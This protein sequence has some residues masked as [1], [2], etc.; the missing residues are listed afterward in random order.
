MNS[1]MNE[2]LLTEEVDENVNDHSWIRWQ[3]AIIKMT[4]MNE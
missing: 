1:K 3:I 4:I 2:I